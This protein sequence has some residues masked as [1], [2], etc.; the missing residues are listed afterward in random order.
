MID[1]TFA[2]ITCTIFGIG[3][4]L[5]DMIGI[6]GDVVHEGGSHGDHGGGHGDHGGLHGDHAGDHGDHGGFHGDHAG[7][8]GDHGG[9]HGDHG[10][11]HGDH[12][13]DHGDHAVDHG[14]A[15][16]DH[17]PLGDSHG[18]HGGDH[19]DQTSDH[20][21]QVATTGT[22][23]EKSSVSAHDTYVER[24]VVGQV[25]SIARSLVHFSLGFG[26][27]G[28]VAL[29]TGRGTVSSLAWSVPVGTVAMIGG[30]LLRRLQRQQLNSQLTTEDMIMEKGEVLVSIGEGQLGK[31]RILVDG[32]YA[33][34]YARASDPVKSLPVGTPVRVID[35]SDECVYVEEEQ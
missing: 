33:E 32:I 26:P 35:F 21:H 31:V 4:T 7:D 17:G 11:F 25:L 19:T 12:A 30:R 3:V 15:G 13:G 23:G 2:Y 16:S 6:L 5:I 8:H 27:V 24:N 34:R 9:F 28:L 10:G 18:T 29:A 14:D 20:G 1:L 22:H